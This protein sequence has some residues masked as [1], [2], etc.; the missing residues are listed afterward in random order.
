MYVVLYTLSFIDTP[1]H[2][3]NTL[4]YYPNTVIEKQ[5][6]ARLQNPETE[7]R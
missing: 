4:I 6:V 7:Y 3:P 2:Y 5:E 1:I